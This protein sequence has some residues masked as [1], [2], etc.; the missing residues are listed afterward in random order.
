MVANNGN[1]AEVF[2]AVNEQRNNLS[3]AYQ[4]VQRLLHASVERLNDRWDIDV[5]D[6]Y[7]KAQ[8]CQRLYYGSNYGWSKVLGV[9]SSSTCMLLQRITA[10]Y[11]TIPYIEQIGPGWYT[12]AIRSCRC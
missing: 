11:H 5:I 7:G 12:T 10:L 9:C 1:G 8:T 3:A 4:Q 6:W 2:R